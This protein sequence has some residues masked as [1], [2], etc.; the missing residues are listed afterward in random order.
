MA[1]NIQAVNDGNFEA[2]V[3]AASNTQPVVVDFWAEWCRPCLMLAPTVAE[4][5]HDYAGKVKVA[6]LNVDE[7]QNSAFRFNI[8]RIP[9]L[10][11]F[12]GVHVVDQIVGAVPKE[13]INDLSIFEERSEEHT[14]ELQSRPHI[15]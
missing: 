15:V 14:P 12:K 11:L 7:A 3:I 1:D 9:T 13:Q 4:I 10:L 5:E 6:K 8:R 2:E